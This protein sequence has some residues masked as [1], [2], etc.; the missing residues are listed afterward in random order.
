MA[1]VSWWWRLQEEGNR[2]R[3]NR[4]RRPALA[5]L[6]VVLLLANGWTAAWG[7]P[8]R[9]AD[10]APP[11]TVTLVGTLQ[12]AAGASSNWDPEAPQTR[13]THKGD[14]LY[15]WSGRLPAGTYEYKFAV[16]GSWAENYGQDGVRD[17][18]NITVTV[19]EEQDVTFWFS[20]RTKKSANSLVYAPIP[21]A[22]RPR[23]VGDFQNELGI[24]EDWK[25]ETSTGFLRDDD[26]DQVYEAVYRVPQ[27]AWQF[28]V[29][30]GTSWEDE[31]YGDGSGEY[32]NATLAVVEPV[33][34]TVTFRY[35]HRTK[36]VTH[37]YVPPAGGPDNRLSA[38]DLYHDTRDPVYRAPTGAV[39]TDQP[40][41]LRLATKRG[42]AQSVLLSYWDD[43]QKKRFSVPMRKAASDFAK[44]KD[45]W[46]ATLTFSSPTVIWY[47]FVVRDGTAR[48]YYGDN[49]TAAQDGHLGAA[50]A[51]NPRDFQLTVYDKRFRTPDWAKHAVVYQI[52]VDRFANGNRENDR[53]KDAVGSRGSTPIEHNAWDDLPDN[54]RLLKP[55]GTCCD[56]DN[57]DD[58]IPDYALKYRDGQPVYDKDGR[59][60]NDFYGGDLEGIIQKLDYLK[61]LGVNTIYL[62]P[63][64][65]A[66]S[67]HKY[68]TADYT[69]IDRMFGDN[70]T[71]QRLADEAK[72][73]GMRILLDGV[74]NHVGDDSVYFDRYGKYYHDLRYWDG[75]E[76][77]R[78]QNIGAYFAWKMKNRDKLPPE[79][80]AR[81]PAWDPAKHRS[82]YE[83]WFSI[84]DDGTYEGWWGF[85]SLPVIQAPGGSELNAG[86]QTGRNYGDFIIR[87][88]DSIARRWIRMGAS[89]WRLDVAPE[90]AD[91]FWRAFRSYLK[92]P[93]KDK[94]G[95]L[96]FPNGEPLLITENWGDATKDVLGDT[97]D[98]TMNYRFRNAV[99]D[100]LLDRPLHDGDA[101]HQPIDAKE[102]DARLM[103]LLED[104]PKEAAYVMM[105][106]MGSHDTMRILRVFGDREPGVMHPDSTYLK[107]LSPEQ[108]AKANAQAKARL[109][110]AWLLQMAF[111]GMPTTYYGDEAGLTGFDD[112]DNR[113]SFP[114]GKEDKELL[115]TFRELMALRNAHLVLRTGD[116]RTLYAEGGT[117][118]VGRSLV[119]DAD[120]L[121]RTAYVVNEAT[122]ETIQVRDHNALA[123]VAV[124]KDGAKRLELDVSGFARDSLVF[125]EKLTGRTYKVADG[126]LI[127]DVPA[128]GG[129]VLITQSG[130]DLVPPSAASDLVATVEED[131]PRAVR[132]TWS[133]VDGAT[134]YTVYRSAVA[135]GG[136]EQVAVVKEPVFR[137]VPP[138]PGQAYSYVVRAL[139]ENGN[140]SADSNE[141]IAVP[142]AP[143][144]WHGNLSGT[145]GEHVIG[146]HR[147]ASA[148]LEVWVDGLTNQPGP[149]P[150][151]VVELGFGRQA[152]RSDWQWVSAAY[153]GEAG[154]NDVYQATFVP[155]ATGTWHYGFRLSTKG[156]HTQAGDWVYSGVQSFT[157]V[158]ADDTI[159][160]P[161]PV[162]AQ[163][164]V[165][166]GRVPLTWSMPD[167][168]DVVAFHVERKGPGDDA[169]AVIARI[170]D[171]GATT[172]VDETVTNDATYAYRVVAIDAA[173]NRSAS[174]TVT[175]T[176]RLVPVAVTFRVR[177]PDYTGTDHPVYLAGTLPEATWNPGAE[178]YRMTYKGNNVWELAVTLEDGQRI[179]YKYARG[180][181]ERVEKGRQ[182]EEIS[183][184]ELVVRDPGN[185][186]MVVEDAVARWRD[187]TL[188]VMEPRNDQ[189][190]TEPRV[191]VRGNAV[192]GSVVKVNGQTVDLDADGYF[193]HE[194]SLHIG[195]NVLEITDGTATQRVRV[196]HQPA[197][198]TPSPA[199]P[200]EAKPPHRPSVAETLRAI[201]DLLARG[202]TTS[203]Q[204]AQLQEWLHRLVHLEEEA[205]QERFEGDR[206][207]VRV[208]EPAI[209]E[210]LRALAQVREALQ[211]AKGVEALAEG[212]GLVRVTL[213]SGAASRA[214]VE[215][216]LDPAV[217]RE[218]VQRAMALV[219][220]GPDR[221]TVRL[222]PETLKPV[223][224]SEGMLTL[225][226]VR[227]DKTAVPSIGVKRRLTSVYTILMKAGDKELPRFQ[228]PLTVTLPLQT[229]PS[230]E[231]GQAW[232]VFAH[233]ASS[234][235]WVYVGG[236][237]AG[238]TVSFAARS[239]GSYAAMVNRVAFAD[240]VGSWSREDVELAAARGWVMGK[241]NRQF[242]PR[243]PVTRAQAAAMLARWGLSAGATG[244]GRPV[245]FIDEAAVPMWARADVKRVAEI[246]WMRGTV[247]GRFEPNRVLT[248]AEAAMVLSRMVEAQ[249]VGANG[250]RADLPYT[251]WQDIPLAYRE[252]VA[253]TTA[254]G[255]FRGLPDGRFAPN[256]PVTREQ[257]AVLLVRLWPLVET[258]SRPQRLTAG[259][260]CV[261]RRDSLCCCGN[262]GVLFWPL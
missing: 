214:A 133:P 71:F 113:R 223:A 37:D 205:V 157:V 20:Y 141:A 23:L 90:V 195:E 174:N 11:V 82:P 235:R 59:W 167:S 224:A 140:A 159:P 179:A 226:V 58:G 104:Y 78:D 207:L 1:R 230:A 40:V 201:T 250:L 145:T 233:D 166:N 75:D 61:S 143:V 15:E 35:D 135:G 88:N 177:V 237:E 171:P 70:E 132:L 221:V 117:Y 148:S 51:E 6:L 137:D 204:R 144:G 56:F 99:I 7:M 210:H 142:Y 38:A 161:S 240:L 131:D 176:P 249:G 85:D 130:Q 17:G 163:P 238:Q 244:D 32:G 173:Y 18:A 184:R 227:T 187:L 108:I 216:Q 256:E 180:S 178:A 160:P 158:A 222:S 21:E 196:H 116:I 26:F 262:E 218:A 79:E 234:R 42:D 203:E 241:G 139:D 252:A 190:V 209:L 153:A 261:E 119:G 191:T 49:D 182:G 151:L 206:V 192:P 183:N 121:G 24:G 106:L 219:V 169:F 247:E 5:L 73:R 94:P 245:V 199:P 194:V 95:R 86:G 12:Q 189:V 259:M 253:T 64:F 150:N 47:H 168:V 34:E 138:V 28:K 198:G 101:S 232:G 30:L 186:T 2:G 36:R 127:F 236:Q 91:D 93:D 69:R 107:G 125:E 229:V 254:L 55:D 212:A 67:N 77:K 175:A 31:H 213:S 105:N 208:D 211:N 89:G 14:G 248:R 39:P 217:V 188:V 87:D 27:G 45:Y 185:G 13:M 149:G 80:R 193:Q 43:R 215:I 72:R 3:T 9:A 4:V 110:M 41:R 46:E 170:P 162:L 197:P 53:A 10:D 68:D 62:N 231:E 63:I 60:G 92:G 50:V 126:K 128:M 111:P 29:V 181:W 146:Y 115:E 257:L 202:I 124:N 154:N 103:E 118:V 114:W 200:G 112:P 165:Q 120:A 52:F 147:A 44:Q 97:F 48:L 25:P 102:L 8:V 54:P 246:G 225:D 83:G 96:A 129:A 98:A 228:A 164:P 122:G 123:I 260:P 76:K 239:S 242:V 172:Y 65:D 134:A 155:D 74:F 258:P 220:E 251:D 156:L 16:N 152:D 81:V 136:Y 33:G 19:P 66:A 57:D 22:K 109:K 100:F 84:R 255:L 243:A